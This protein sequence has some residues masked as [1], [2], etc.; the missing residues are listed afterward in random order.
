MRIRGNTK[1]LTIQLNKDEIEE[2]THVNWIELNGSDIAENIV[3]LIAKECDA[4]KRIITDELCTAQ[5][6]ECCN[7]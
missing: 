3:C 6:W 2:F 1:G 7:D 5:R 4:Y